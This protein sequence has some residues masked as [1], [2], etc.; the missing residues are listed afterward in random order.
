ML[1]YGETASGGTCLELLK[2]RHTDQPSLRLLG[3]EL[4][5]THNVVNQPRRDSDS[6]RDWPRCVISEFEMTPR[7]PLQLLVSLSIVQAG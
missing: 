6:A 2:N 5:R 1:K 3:N 4:L 7:V